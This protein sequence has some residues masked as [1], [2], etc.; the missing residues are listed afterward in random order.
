MDI[1]AIKEA[2]REEM[3]A[4]F[5][6]R[7]DARKAVRSI[8]GD[9]NVMTFDSAEDIYKFACEQAGMDVNEIVSYKDAFK[10]LTAGKSKLAL[11][12]SSISGSDEECFKDI[13]IA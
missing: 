5:K 12:A 9:V 1:D 10:G 8:V 4:D 7:E 2:V 6:A 13:R 11:D 3:K